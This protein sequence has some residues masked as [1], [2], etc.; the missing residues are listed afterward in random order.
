MKKLLLLLTVMVAFAA[1]AQQGYIK[2]SL[3]VKSATL[4]KDVEYSLY[5]PP[6]YDQSNRRYP[7]LY[8]L[9]GYTDDE[10]GWTQF[11]EVK[12]TANRQIEKMEMT[13]MIIAMPDGGVSWYIN[14]ADGKVKYEDFFINEFIP[15]IDATYRTRTEKRYRGI[16]G[17]SMGG[18]GSLIMA[19]KHPDLFA[20]AAPLS[21]GIF[22][23]DELIGM[24]DDN[25]NNVFGPCYGKAKGADRINDHLNKNWILSIVES[26]NADDL[27]KVKYY[28]DCGDKDFL[29]KGNMALHSLLIDKKVPHEFRVREG[30]HNWDYW[31]TALPEVFKFVS[32][33][34]HQ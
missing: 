9:H 5:F 15:H 30:V 28:I 6:G 16:A 24:P 25:W 14:S 7:V 17:L 3:K 32:A 10:T 26:A 12:A 21:S 11:G 20:T 13:E 27:K 2:E 19:M 29:I 18:H 4:G 22:T 34:F 31:R 8:L 1:T 23:K 33:S